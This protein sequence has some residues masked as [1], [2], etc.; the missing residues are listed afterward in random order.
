MSEEEQESGGFDLLLIGT[1]IGVVVGAGIGATFFP[2]TETVTQTEIKWLNA[3]G[4]E[5]DVEDTNLYFEA[6]NWTKTCIE[7]NSFNGTTTGQ[8]CYLD[9]TGEL[10]ED[11][12][13]YQ[14]RRL[15]RDIDVEE[16]FRKET[17]HDELAEVCEDH[18]F[19]CSVTVRVNLNVCDVDFQRND[20]LNLRKLDGKN[21]VE[22]VG[23]Q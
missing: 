8:T 21:C 20:V 2:D 16:Y 3:S 23:Y 19:A 22:V 15:A 4:Q 18:A 6:E 14:L 7:G 17:E 1:I 13:S 12:D 10:K 9:V 11:I 5:V